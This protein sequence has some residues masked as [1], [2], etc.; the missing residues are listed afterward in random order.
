[1]TFIGDCVDRLVESDITTLS[2][3]DK[4]DLIALGD[5]INHNMDNYKLACNQIPE[6]EAD[7]SV[8]SNQNPRITALLV[9]SSC[10]T[11]SLFTSSTTIILIMR[12]HH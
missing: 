7:Q 1:M 5:L 10:S 2:A 6:L 4:A 3:S 12:I 11:S 9:V 8:N